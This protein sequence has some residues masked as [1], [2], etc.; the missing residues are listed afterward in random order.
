MLWQ[1]LIVILFNLY[2]YLLLFFR[3]HNK[4]II[5]TKD[6]LK[7]CEIFLN[8]NL[9]LLNYLNVLFIFKFRTLE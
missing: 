4:K 6:N 5:Q 9:I 2:I 3:L 8:P 1:I 7:I